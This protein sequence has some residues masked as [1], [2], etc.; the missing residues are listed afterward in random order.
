MRI[1]VVLLLAAVGCLTSCASGALRLVDQAPTLSQADSR[2][3]HLAARERLDKI[4]PRSWIMEIR[5]V[6]A[7][8][9]RARFDTDQNTYF[10]VLQKRA[11]NWRVIRIERVSP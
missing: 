4:A 6:S 11:G 8:E 3:V 9:V 1:S 7:G 10:M 5:V 2:A